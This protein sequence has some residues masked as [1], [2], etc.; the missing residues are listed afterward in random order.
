MKL[1]QKKFKFHEA[2]RKLRKTFPLLQPSFENFENQLK[3]FLTFPSSK[4]K[5]HE[6]FLKYLNCSFPLFTFLFNSIIKN[7]FL[8]TFQKHEINKSNVEKRDFFN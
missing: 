3:I 6:N 7:F 1:F 8:K 4:L 2:R 5:K